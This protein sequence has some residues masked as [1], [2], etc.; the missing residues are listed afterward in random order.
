MAKDQKKPYNKPELKADRIE[1][2]VYGDYNAPASETQPTLP[3]D[4]EH[5]RGPKDVGG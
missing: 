4:K 3:I 5:Y 2:G 1:L